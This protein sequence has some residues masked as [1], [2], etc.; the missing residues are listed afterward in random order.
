MSQMETMP[1]IDGMLNSEYYSGNH[2]IHVTTVKIPSDESITQIEDKTGYR[3][4]IS[5]QTH[6][7]VL[8][9]FSGKRVKNGI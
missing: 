9:I 3:F 6:D 2:T 1:K 7:G 4:L 8:S 5:V